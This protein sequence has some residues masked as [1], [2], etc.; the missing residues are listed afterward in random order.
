MI[1]L[2]ARFLIFFKI[3]IYFF[4]C[5]GLRNRG[6]VLEHLVSSGLIVLGMDLLYA[7]YVW[8]GTVKHI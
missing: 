6:H 3:Y 1:P 2:F 7:N 5:S 8:E 4:N